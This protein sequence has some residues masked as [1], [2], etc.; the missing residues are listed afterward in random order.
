LVELTTNPQNVVTKIRAY[1]K[2]A[3]LKSGFDPYEAWYKIDYR[4]RIEVE[5]VLGKMRDAGL[6]DVPHDEA[7]YYSSR[8]PDATWRVAEKLLPMIREAGM[9]ELFKME[10]AMLPVCIEMMQNGMA[11]DVDKLTSLSEKCIVL[12][13]EQA[14]ICKDIA[15]YGFNPNSHD[16]V[17]QLVYEELGFEVTK[18]TKKAKKASTNDKELSKIKHPIIKP[19][20]EYRKIL[21]VRSSYAEKLPRYVERNESNVATG[22][23]DHLCVG[24]VHPN[25]RL[26]GTDTGRLKVT[27]P[28][29]QTIP[30]KTE[31]GREVR[32][33]FI[34]R[35]GKQVVFVDLSQ[36]EMRI[37]AHAS[38]CD[39]LVNLFRIGGDIH[40]DT[41][42]QVFG[43]SRDEAKEDKYRKPISNL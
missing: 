43:I 19:I 30:V 26:S 35:P 38:N 33:A 39:N 21:K 2:K 29:L 13:Q 24:I 4:E 34:A 10:M 37:L 23:K 16:Q 20:L 9:S 40:S 28:P 32:D 6:H 14:E 12:M 3:E 15:G 11:V 7:V 41:A 27:D 17:R 36:I 5:S 1:I 22:G 18:K 25:I 8:D 31:L 42:V